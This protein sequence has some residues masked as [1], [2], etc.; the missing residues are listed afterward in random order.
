LLTAEGETWKRSR[1]AMA[2]VFTP[3]H[4]SGFAEQMLAQSLAFKDR[5][6]A[7]ADSN[8]QAQVRSATLP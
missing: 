1:K 2:P 8:S 6:A 4:A 3:R 7:A 5:Y